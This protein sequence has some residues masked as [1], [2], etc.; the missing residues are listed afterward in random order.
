MEVTIDGDKGK[1]VWKLND[2]IIKETEHDLPV[3]SSV[4]GEL[5]QDEVVKRINS[6]EIGQE[7]IEMIKEAILR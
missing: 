1:E 6:P 7:F 2:E 3:I 5:S 4:Q